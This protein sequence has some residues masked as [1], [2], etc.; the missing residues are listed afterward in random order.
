[1]KGTSQTHLGADTPKADVLCPK[2]GLRVGNWNVRT[3]YQTSKLSQV[4]KEFD[5]YRLNFLGMTEARLVG[6]DKKFLNS[7]HTLLHSGR[8]DGKHEEGVALLLSKEVSR[9][10]LEWKPLGSRM[11][12]ARF[13]GKYTKLTL[14]VCYAPTELAEEEVKD[15]FYDQLQSA[16][17]DIPS[18]DMLL[19]IGDLNARTGSCNRG[20]ERVMGIHGLGTHDLNDNGGRM[21]DFC[22][23]NGLLVGGTLFP[24]KDIHKV[25][26]RAPD[27]VTKTQV[28]HILI[29]GKWKSSLQDVRVYRGADC[30][31]DHDLVVGQVKLKLRI[32][33]KRNLRSRKIDSDKLRDTETRDRFR[34]ELQNR[35]Q[36]LSSDS[37]REISL[38][39]FNKAII[40]TGET[41]L[42]FKERAKK[43]WIQPATW[44][45]IE[46][47]KGMKQKLNSTQSG[48]AREQLRAEYSNLDKDVK[49]MAKAD[50]KAY[51]DNLADEAEQA[52]GRRDLRSL[53]SITRTLNGKY[54]HSNVLV[55]DSEGNIITKESEQTPRWKE[56]FESLL[57][58][59]DPE[60][61]P[62][63][64][65]ANEVLD[66]NTEPPTLHEVSLA[67]KAMKCGKAGGLDGVTAD[68]LKAEDI[69]TP[70]LLK[71][72]L[73]QIWNS[74]EIP[75]SW[76]TGLIVKLPKKGDL[77]DC[78]NWRGI[79]LLS[80]TS[81]VLSRI[82]H[83][84]IA[85]KL[86]AH[87]REEQAGF[88]P[89]RSCSEHIFTMRQILEQSHEWNSSLYVNFLDFKKAF[90]SVHRDSLWKILRHYGIPD[91]LVGIVKMLYHDSS[92]RVLHDGELSETF[93][94]ETGVKQG[95][96]LSPFL[97]S[98]AV[99]WIMTNTVGKGKRGLQWT[100]AKRLEDLDFADDIALLSQRCL[101]MQQKTE[102]TADCAKQIGM[103]TNVPKTKHLRM[104]A[105]SSERIQLHGA[106]IEEV[107]EFS[108]LGSKMTTSGSCDAEV[109]AR[110]SKAS[111]A[112]GMLKSTWK[113]GRISLKTKLRLF[114]SNVVSTLLYGSES[115]KM[116]K[117]IERKLE[118]FQRRC[119]R[120]I[121]MVFWPNTISNE[122]LYARTS[123]S[124][125]TPQI[126]RRRWR[127]IGHVLRLPTDAIARVA[128]R[129][130][131]QGSRSVGRPGE[132]W[133]RTVEAEMKQQGWSWSFLEHTAKDR[134]EWRS[135]VEALCAPGHRDD[136]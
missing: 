131:P 103:E 54:T 73:G 43:V 65:D 23:L 33:R 66:I 76:T 129:W 100:F 68:M 75:E 93:K 42:G 95:C 32:A 83:R 35:F 112:F 44:H 28:D 49:R 4:V 1:M 21:C 122:D 38:D 113:S 130:T 70:K 96:V 22:E 16:I 105:T 7:G 128:L 59:P 50:K 56:H 51:V 25:T 87:L 98:I 92:A 132:T 119:L 60:F 36:L 27:G 71:D 127:W 61:V 80:V 11:L 2:T 64:Q 121:L 24:H 117:T 48:V 107:E 12:R 34:I 88:R 94:V 110:L 111:Q 120:R 135:L 31:S 46:E 86:D 115:W 62:D 114:E 133:R 45:K 89:G 58:R 52:A 134:V 124:P 99:D 123:S 84:R 40:E 14:V 47:R 72:I 74:E 41:I 13:G 104:N 17:E 39:D 118:V 9:S 101:D 29:N 5:K 3:L 26:W 91:K 10:L 116:T 109:K 81:K 85:E 108:Y 82:I 106:D 53:Y 102:D 126:R 6:H 90:D 15:G 69:M 37:E 19:I 125:I 78:N 136:G 30:G 57:N 79:T 20:R 8:K 63:I 77:S 67:I 18:H 55:R 97:F